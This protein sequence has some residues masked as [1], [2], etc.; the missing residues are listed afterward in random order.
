[1]SG[2]KKLKGTN[3]KKIIVIVLF[4]VFTISSCIPAFGTQIEKVKEATYSTGGSEIKY[5]ELEHSFTYPEIVK[6]GNY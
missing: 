4:I 6:H 1:M 5:I 3:S 2:G